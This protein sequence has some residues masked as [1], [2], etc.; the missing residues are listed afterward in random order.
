MI[1]NQLP[2]NQAEFPLPEIGI[3]YQPG[4][5]NPF[6]PY[7]ISPRNTALLPGGNPIKIRW[8]KVVNVS[9]YIV[10]IIKRDSDIILNKTTDSTELDFD[11]SCLELG[12]NYTIE[13]V[14]NVEKLPA[15]NV[16]AKTTFTISGNVGFEVEAAPST[17][18]AESV[19]ALSNM[20]LGEQIEES[21]KL[22]DQS[23]KLSDVQKAIQK[24]KLYNSLDLNYDAI[25]VLETFILDSTSGDRE[26][27][28]NIIL[29]LAKM[30][31]KI[32]LNLR[33]EKCYWQAISLAVS[34]NDFETSAEAQKGLIGTKLLLATSQIEQAEQLSS[35]ARIG[36]FSA[37]NSENSSSNVQ[38]I[39]KLTDLTIS[40]DRSK[41]DFLSSLQPAPVALVRSGGPPCRKWWQCAG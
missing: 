31:G 30:Y 35:Q 6:V 17:L 21:I 19:A 20:S 32:G 24:A 33:A 34:N 3:E 41:L 11:I 28:A 38:L 10:K 40:L 12:T 8:H 4:G 39:G 5:S 14:A 37:E 26:Q 27:N 16:E 1:D 13:V 15:E 25:N 22:I 18:D 9:S 7:I 29:N 36:G 23:T 2:D